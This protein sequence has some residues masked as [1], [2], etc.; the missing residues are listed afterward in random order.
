MADDLAQRATR[1]DDASREL[2]RVGAT[3]C[4]NEEKSCDE[5]DECN[6]SYGSET[7]LAIRC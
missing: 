5:N 4:V 7:L 6:H 1:R 3:G 2:T